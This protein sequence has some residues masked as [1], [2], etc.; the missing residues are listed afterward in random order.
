MLRVELF[1]RFQSQRLVTVIVSFE[2][3]SQ[4]HFRVTTLPQLCYY[5][6]ITH[7]NVPEGFVVIDVTLRNTKEGFKNDGMTVLPFDN[8]KTVA[9]WGVWTMHMRT[10]QYERLE[11]PLRLCRSTPNING[12]W[13]SSIVQ[14][15]DS[16]IYT[17]HSAAFMH[18]SDPPR[19]VDQMV[20]RQ[21]FGSQTNNQSS[22][23]NLQSQNGL[24]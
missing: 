14:T 2:Q 5:N 15:T 12:T 13:S 3:E 8:C 6:P 7:E 24:F 19:L 17:H 18:S 22:S 10:I 21:L 4:S 16:S 1:E 23:I 9:S 11:F 20:S